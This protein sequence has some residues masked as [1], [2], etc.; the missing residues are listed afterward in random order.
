[1]TRSMLK[2]KELPDQFWGEVV[3]TAVYLLN[4]SPTNVV[5]YKTPY[6]AWKN[7]KP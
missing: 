4:I 7:K 6:H 5:R 3:A 2:A 1:M